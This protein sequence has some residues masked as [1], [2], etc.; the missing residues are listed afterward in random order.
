M[1]NKLGRHKRGAFGHLV[2]SLFAV[3][4]ILL[5]IIVTTFEEK[6]E[7]DVRARHIQRITDTISAQRDLRGFFDE[8]HTRLEKSTREDD[9]G[10]FMT[11]LETFMAERYLSQDRGY[12][13]TFY[14]P[15]GKKLCGTCQLRI[16]P[17]A[18]QD[19]GS[20]EMAIPLRRGSQ[21]THI[22]VEVIVGKRTEGNIAF[23]SSGP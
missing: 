15:N 8:E 12:I 11:M 7:D 16:D 5:F 10:E 23:E 20:F 4:F 18:G 13:V 17:P 22:D 14:D 6:R 1:N 19:M 2:G 3:G 21:M 9:Y